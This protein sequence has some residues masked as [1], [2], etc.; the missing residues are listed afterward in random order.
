[1]SL[2]QSRVMDEQE[3]LGYEIP[4]DILDP[5]IPTIFVDQQAADEPPF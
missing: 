2:I 1:M 5:D 3:R 4:P